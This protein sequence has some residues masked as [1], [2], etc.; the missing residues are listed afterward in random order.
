MASKM[1]KKSINEYEA[2]LRFDLSPTLLRWLTSNAI[3][4]KT[5][6]SYQERDEIYYYDQDELARLD[7]RMAGKWPKTDKG[8]RPH[9]PEGIKREIRQEARSSCPVCNKSHGEIA[10]I[11]CVSATHCN[12]PKN[13]IFLCPDHHTEYDNAR[14]PANIDREEV[15]ILKSALKVF[16]RQIWKVRG[17]LIESYLAGLNSAKSLLGIHNV[18][19]NIIPNDEFKSILEKIATSTETY[20]DAE[21]DHANFASPD[22]VSSAIDS[23][24][25]QN[26]E[27]ICP[28]C[29]GHGA[30]NFYDPC[31]VCLGN[32]EIDPETKEQ[33]DLSAYKLVSC[34][35]CSGSG[36]NNGT[37]CPACGA[38]GQVSQSY[39][40]HHDW[41]MYD[42]VTCKLCE[43]NGKYDGDDCPPCGGEGQVSQYFYDYHDWSRYDL[44]TCNLCDGTG[45]H[46]GNDCPPCSGEGKVTQG[47]HENHDWS[48]YD[49]V[50]CKLCDGTGKHDG[51][52][53]PPCLGEGQVSQAFYD[54]HDWSK[55]DSVTCKLCEGTGM[56][57]GDDCPPCRGEG[58]VTE[59]FYYDHDWSRYETVECQLCKGEGRYHANDCIPCRGEG[60]VSQK[61][62]RL[63]NWRQYK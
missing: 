24:I 34:R 3:F 10:H 6:I 14:I 32:G 23:Y 25:E 57:D 37:D 16:Q 18:V 17:N 60:R 21:I 52:Y 50:T 31:P 33:I 59:G 13:L 4:D 38:E 11:D 47:F 46:D 61:F 56:H 20:S 55:Y 48:N 45:V 5:K 15:L 29:E 27:H 51:D 44:V 2:A 1:K 28:L 41:S 49:L 62:N 8:Q 43:G 22:F 9:I 19:R 7:I 30:T 12:H 36:T 53:C 58:K 35:L 42:L 40:D 39:Y 26:Q 54:Y 63:H